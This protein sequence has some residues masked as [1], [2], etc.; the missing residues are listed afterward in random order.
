MLVLP[1]SAVP[2]GDVV[3][4]VTMMLVASGK[5][6]FAEAACSHHALVPTG[7]KGR[8]VVAAVS[9]AVEEVLTESRSGIKGPAA[10]KWPHPFTAVLWFGYPTCL[11]VGRG[12]TGPLTQPYTPV[13]SPYP[14][15]TED[16]SKVKHCYWAHPIQQAKLCSTAKYEQIIGNHKSDLKTR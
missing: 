16:R 6:W 3:S 12:D 2:R 4:M 10:L 15:L 14:E 13:Q 7:I 11:E 5:T 9:T 8:E 1:K